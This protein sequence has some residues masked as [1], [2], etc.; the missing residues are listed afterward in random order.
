MHDQMLCSVTWKCQQLVFGKVMKKFFRWLGFAVLA[1]IA[2]A[3]AAVIYLNFAFGREL[4]RR[5]QVAETLSISLPAGPAEIAE[6]KRLAQLTGCTHCHAENLAGAVP[7]DIPGVA[8]FVA[9]NLTRILPQ[10]SDAELVGLLRRGVKRDGTGAWLMPSQM[11]RHLHDEDLA[12]LVAWVRSVPASDGVTERTRIHLMGRFIVVTGKFK[13]A[14]QQIE[15]LSA[16]PPAEMAG[17]GA[18]LVMNLCS[19]CHGQDLAGEPEAQAPSLA[20]AKGYSAEDFVRLMNTGIGLGG[21][22]FELM[23]PTAKARFS[24]LTAEEADAMHAWLQSRP[25]D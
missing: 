6:G 12:R 14:A 20:V 22:T 1:L 3:I 17:R 16:A 9:P 11:F 18:Y 8:R 7:L 23:T 2:I 4:A 13:S 21:R 24:H 15:E 25:G 5:Y 19:E 10:Y